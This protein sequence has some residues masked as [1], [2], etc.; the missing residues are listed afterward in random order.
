MPNEIKKPTDEMLEIVHCKKC[1]HEEYYGMMTWL[2]G[3]T[4]CRKCTYENWTNSSKWLPGPKDYTFPL[5]D[6]GIDW[7]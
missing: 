4:Y 5:Y 3:T 7:R 2:N 6:D 1:D